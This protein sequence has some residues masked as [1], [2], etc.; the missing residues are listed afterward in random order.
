M[1]IGISVRIPDIKNRMASAIRS[2]YSVEGKDPKLVADFDDEYY[3]ANGGSTT[4]SNLIT[5]ARA[6]NATMTDG[7]GPELVTNGG[8]DSDSDWTLGTG[9]SISGGKANHTSGTASQIIS[10][11]SSLLN[12]KVYE[13]RFTVSNRTAGSLLLE[14]AIWSSAETISAN[15]T[16]VFYKVKSSN[17]PVVLYGSGTFNGSIDNVSV[18]EIPVIKWAPHNL[19]TYSEDFSQSVWFKHSGSNIGF[20]G[21][22]S[23]PDGGVAAFKLTNVN[24]YIIQNAFTNGNKKLIWARTVSG[25]GTVGLLSH[26]SASGS[27][28]S[29]TEDWQ[30]FSRDFDTTE[31]GG[32]SFYAVDF[33]AGDLTE[34]LVYAPH[35]YRS[36]LGGMVDNPDRGD[37]YVP[38]TASAVYLPRRG[39][40][41][42]NGYEWVNDGV[43]AESE[44]RSN[45]VEYSNDFTDPQW[46]KTAC[47]V[48]TNQAVS[49]DGNTNASK[50]I[51]NT[52]TH[53]VGSYVAF[54]VTNGQA[55]SFFAKAGEFNY[56]IVAGP[57]TTD[58]VWFDLENGLVKTQ[59]SGVQSASIEDYG[60]GW[61]RCTVISSSSGS[62]G[63]SVYAA[64]ADNT[65]S[66][67]G[68]GSDGIYIYGAQCELSTTP[69][70]YIP[71]SGSSVTRAAET[72]TIPSAKLP[73]PTP[74][75]IGDEL[76]T[77]GTFDTDTS[78]WTARND[79]ILT[80][81]SNRLR[82]SL[83]VTDYAQAYQGFST[84]SGQVYRLTMN[85]WGSNQPARWRLGTSIA[86]NDVY[87]SDSATSDNVSWDVVF[88]AQSSTTYLTLYANSTSDTGYAEY[89][90]VSVRSIN[91]LSVSI[92]MDGRLSFA[93]TGG[94]TRP[95][96]WRS[97]A[98][99]Y[100]QAVYSTSGTDALYFAQKDGTTYDDVSQVNAFSPDILVPYNIS[101]RHGSTFINGAIDGVA[102]TANTT[103]TALPDLSTTDL[104]LVDIYMG[105]IK[106][107]RIWDKD[108]TDTGI[109]EATAPSLEPS[110]SLSFDSTESSFVD[111]G[112]SE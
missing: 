74:Q 94:I 44:S 39:H 68:N 99:N 50:L 98:N 96:I 9:W 32:V 64:S 66:I 101:S 87:Q 86:N 85:S 63:C 20:E 52:G 109:A 17:G 12:G 34:I 45:L 60:N 110:L 28:Y 38:T 37:S 75:V 76:V 24:D 30:L 5:H 67:T 97:G 112:W 62:G 14:G 78:G 55:T 51:P 59:Q 13:V 49:P 108:L 19:L 18:R 57:S 95:Y 81:N 91:P 89:D 29:L 82:V 69:S 105:T 65:V 84:V 73:W 8:F 100:I 111:K 21:G 58:G 56:A 1:S 27:T 79:A 90:N 107:L 7:Y 26:N 77:N 40:H 104:D 2:L 80:V 6:G 61:Y 70:S 83:N 103:P 102:L 93:D 23:D 106:T 41:V 11:D 16:F 54:T 33:R 36:D 22:F 47:S 71:T 46:A 72:F 42:Y 25:T 31:T 3:R 92:Q 35:V 4:F 53:S 10:T 48:S 88:V 43:L 15:G